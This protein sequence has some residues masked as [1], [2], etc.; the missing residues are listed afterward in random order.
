MKP[1]FTTPEAMAGSPRFA[2]L[3]E[4]KEYAEGVRKRMRLEAHQNS[5][6]VPR[7][8]MMR[9]EAGELAPQANVAYVTARYEL[10]IGK[11]PE[12][13][14]WVARVCD[15][16]ARKGQQSN[17]REDDGA[18]SGVRL[19]EPPAGGPG[20]GVLSG[21]VR[22]PGDV[23]HPEAGVVA[24]PGGEVLAGCGEGVREA[25]QELRRED[26]GLCPV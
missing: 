17:A 16:E 6:C 13:G 19:R 7:F 26:A 1:L 20:T 11:E 15:R 9:T 10:V 25:P 22:R 8:L 12:T 4:A 24:V 23:S 21:E 3:R 5:L 2:T 14:R 18:V